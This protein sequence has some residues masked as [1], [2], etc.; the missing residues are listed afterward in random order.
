MIEKGLGKTHRIDSETASKDYT[1]KK[2]IERAITGYDKRK[3]DIKRMAQQK[4]L[5]KHF[6][7]SEREKR[8]KEQYERDHKNLERD[9]ERINY[10]KIRKLKSRFEGAF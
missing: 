2:K 7:E 3:S 9:R 6:K 8:L 1:D 10:D 4:L 5:R